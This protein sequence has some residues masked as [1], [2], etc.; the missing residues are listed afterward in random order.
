MNKRQLQKQKTRKL[1][2]Q[3][4]K[5]YFIGKGFL[6]TTTAEIAS[7]CGIAHGTLFLHFR[8]KEMLIIE[9]LD[10]QLESISLGILE[11]IKDSRSLEEMLGNYLQF[12]EQEEDF[13]IVIAKELPFYSEELRRKIIFRE[14]YIRSKF[15]K[16]IA[17]GIEEGI[18][19]E[20]DPVTANTY[21]FSIINYYLSLKEIFVT[22][23][24]VI[25]KFREKIISTFM[26]FIS[27][28]NR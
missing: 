15:S 3:T 16:A 6:K 10:Q 26:D 2:L 9:I 24:S 12:I 13:F 22:E 4:A 18:F 27:R 8:N 20:C 28:R 23:G 14:S 5:Q 21:L 19:I 1:I 17:R 25:G 7:E 11:L